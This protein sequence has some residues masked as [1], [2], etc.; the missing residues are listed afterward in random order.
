MSISG[1]TSARSSSARMSSTTSSTIGMITRRSWCGA[2]LD[3][4]VDGG[5]PPTSASA[6]ANGVHGG[7]DPVDGRV[8]G[9]AVR[10]RPVSVA[11]IIDAAVLGH[12]RRDVG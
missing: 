1:A 11:W 4:E 2:S 8:R 5:V 7:A 9:L 10:A 6:P 3:V 12:R